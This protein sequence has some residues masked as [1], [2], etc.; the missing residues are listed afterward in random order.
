M[1]LGAKEMSVSF[2]QDCTNRESTSHSEP[3]LELWPQNGDQRLLD[4]RLWSSGRSLEGGAPPNR[5][6]CRCTDLANL[7]IPAY[8]RW[9]DDDLNLARDRLGT[10]KTGMCAVSAQ[11][12]SATN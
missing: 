9:L 6:R 5:R 1:L 11:V 2:A 10:P 12:G 8:C 3:S 4:V 7:L